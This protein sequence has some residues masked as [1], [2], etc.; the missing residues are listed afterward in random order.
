MLVAIIVLA[1][2]GEA[3]GVVE[4]SGA[5]TLKGDPVSRDQVES[6]A[7]PENCNWQKAHFL[8]LSWPQGRTYDDPRRKRTYVK[9][10]NGVLDFAPDLREG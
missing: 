1:A 3:D 10:P 5:W 4:P 7:G 6:N 9:D 8:G 2:C